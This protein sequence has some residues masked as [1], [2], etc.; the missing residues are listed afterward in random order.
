MK[1][2]K[3][4]TVEE[5]REYE[6]TVSVGPAFDELTRRLAEAEWKLAEAEE[7]ARYW[8]ETCHS[9]HENTVEPL[10][11]SLAESKKDVWR[12]LIACVKARGYLI[13]YHRFQ[14][15]PATRWIWD[16]D[17]AKE[18]FEELHAAIEEQN[19]SD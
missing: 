18:A 9:Q 4:M 3:D 7:R 1:D 10:R 19:R 17:A 15:A 8:E 5:L 16:T 13:R 12:L 6:L 2:L 14:N 11:A